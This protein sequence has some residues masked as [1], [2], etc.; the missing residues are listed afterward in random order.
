MNLQLIKKEQLVAINLK[1]ASTLLGQ[2][3]VCGALFLIF[4]Y[5]PY[6]THASNNQIPGED[7]EIELESIRVQIKDVQVKIDVARQSVDIYL[8]ELQV[9]EKSIMEITLN[10]ENINLSIESQ[11]KK[12]QQL[13]IESAEQ[14]KILENER[15]L[16]A[17]QIR[18][19][20]KTG[21]HDF[22]KLLL[23]QEKPE[24]IGRLMAYHDYYNRARSNKIS[25]IQLTLI[26]LKQLEIAID[27][28]TRELE[29]LKE[30]QINRFE[31]LAAYGDERTA[32]INQIN[33]Y[34]SIQ[35]RALRN[36][37]LD[38]QELSDLVNNLKSEQDIVGLYENLPPFESLKGKLD[39]PV[40]GKIITRYGSTKKEGKLRWNGV[41][42]SAT[43]GNDVAAISSGKVIFADWFRNMGLLII[44]DHGYGYMSLYGHNERLLK[45]PGDFISTGDSIAKVGN[46]GG[47]SVS[48]LY[49]EI[50]QQGSPM[51]PSL[52]CQG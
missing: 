39:W 35:D 12:L 38:E 24:L 32:I 43:P 34:I 23:N 25:E 6:I 3:P 49:F 28:E 20:Y 10:L 1:K 16:L 47:Q 42:I 26:N 19:A 22:L 11:F 8:N 41:R 5:F 2:F 36:L 40:S 9:N 18:V 31:L 13:H 52:W 29:T 51:N 37:Q 50:R 7:K 14:E 45:K 48:A 21:R 46:T 15:V 17:D 27:K 33:D 4:S 30:E 44:I